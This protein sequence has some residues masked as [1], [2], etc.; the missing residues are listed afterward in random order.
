MTPLW[1]HHRPGIGKPLSLSAVF[2]IK[3]CLRRYTIVELESYYNTG[4][5]PKSRTV[6]TKVF[7]IEKWKFYISGS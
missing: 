2:K 5:M 1:N 6:K 4:I 7:V 3:I